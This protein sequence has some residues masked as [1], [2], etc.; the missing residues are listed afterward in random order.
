MVIKGENGRNPMAESKPQTQPPSS[1]PTG[2]EQRAPSLTAL[3]SNEA[4]TEKP[5]PNEK[6][7]GLLQADQ[8][9]GVLSSAPPLSRE[10]GLSLRRGGERSRRSSDTLTASLFPKS[11]AGTYRPRQHC[12]QKSSH[13]HLQLNS[14]PWSH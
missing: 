3:I 12:T 11:L 9:S 5:S 10:K 4:N 7:H 8:D 14:T 6:Q 2:R 1:P 13:I